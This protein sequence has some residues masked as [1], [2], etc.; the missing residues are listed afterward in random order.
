MP[1]SY[2]TLEDYHQYCYFWATLEQFL[3]QRFNPNP[4][5][6]ESAYQPHPKEN[7]YVVTFRNFDNSQHLIVDCDPSRQGDPFHIQ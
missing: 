2:N 5:I 7:R 4:W 1:N 6:F 3:E